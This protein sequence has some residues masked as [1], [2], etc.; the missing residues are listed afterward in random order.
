MNAKPNL[1]IKGDDLGALVLAFGP[2]VSTVSVV[3]GRSVL[4]TLVVAEPIGRR[5]IGLPETQD[6]TLTVVLEDGWERD[7]VLREY[8]RRI[9]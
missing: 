6:L 5:R 7:A 3:E 8:E 9:R 1:E 2:W 4:V